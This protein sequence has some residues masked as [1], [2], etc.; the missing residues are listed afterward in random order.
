MPTICCV[1]SRS[2]KITKKELWPI[3]SHPDL[4]M[5]KLHIY[6]MFCKLFTRTKSF[7]TVFFFKFIDFTDEMTI[8]FIQVY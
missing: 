2:V 6:L 5:D 4:K 3:Y 1:Q 7:F 8:T